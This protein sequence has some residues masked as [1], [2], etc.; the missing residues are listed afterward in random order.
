M[1]NEYRFGN[2]QVSC[3]GYAYPDDPFI[4]QGSCGVSFTPSIYRNAR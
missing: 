1:D 2:I 3:E 4:L